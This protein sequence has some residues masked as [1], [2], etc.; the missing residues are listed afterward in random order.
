[1]KI[2]NK[3]IILLPAFILLSGCASVMEGSDQT[4]NVNTTGCEQ[5]GPMRCNVTNSE[6]SSVLTAPASVAVEKARGPM[7]ISCESRDGSATGLKRIESSYESMNVGNILVGGIIGIGVDAA[8]G[9]MW[10]YP[11]SV[12]VEM[13]CGNLSST[14]A[15]GSIKKR[16]PDGRVYVGAFKNDLP[17]GHGVLSLSNGDKYNG[18][19][20]G[21]LY[22]GSGIYTW[23]S[24]KEYVGDFTRG[25]SKGHGTIKFTNGDE[26]RGGVLD[27]T[28]HG[29]GTMKYWN[30]SI[31][32]GIWL[33]GVFQTD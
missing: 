18:N 2:I 10:K 27:G 13:I 30:N 1:M 16:W 3:I 23:N 32:K 26:Y 24:G 14:N 20:I 5:L 6:G 21:G 9:A 7:T 12:N 22:D 17:N 29:Q 4:V 33:E 19:F 25:I 11:S 31:N 8:T 15:S 28:P